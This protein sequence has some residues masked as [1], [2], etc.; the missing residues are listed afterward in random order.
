MDC[1]QKLGR[2]SL[3]PKA[4]TGIIYW[5]PTCSGYGAKL[6]CGISVVDPGA[7][8]GASTSFLVSLV[9]GAID[10][11]ETGSTRVVKACWVPGMVPPLSGRSTGANDNRM[12]LAA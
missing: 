2:D 5:E 8:P 7:V 3:F 4:P 6:A 12:A 10:G 11:G 9:E 1:V